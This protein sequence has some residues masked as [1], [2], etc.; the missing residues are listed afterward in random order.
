MRLFSSALVASMLFVWT[1]SAN[2]EPRYDS[3]AQ[4]KAADAKID[5][6]TKQAALKNPRLYLAIIQ[7][8]HPLHID[9]EKNWLGCYNP[10][11][12]RQRFCRPSD[13]YV[14]EKVIDTHGGSC[15]RT[16]IIVSCTTVAEHGSSDAR[17]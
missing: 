9:L 8:M 10:K 3:G 12:L 13:R 16:W 4:L 6:M 5:A 7:S 17:K 2:G 15:G 1:S 14:E 11:A